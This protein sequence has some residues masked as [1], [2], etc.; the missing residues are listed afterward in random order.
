MEEPLRIS[1]GKMIIGSK[2]VEEYVVLINGKKNDEKIRVLFINFATS[3]TLEFFEFNNSKILADEI[4]DLFQQKKIKTVILN[5]FEV[6]TVDFKNNVEFCK[7]LQ[8]KFYFFRIPFY[9]ISPFNFYLNKKIIAANVEINVGD[10]LLMFDIDDDKFDAAELNFTNDGYEYINLPKIEYFGNEKLMAQCLQD[11][12]VAECKP[13]KIIL[14]SEFSDL[15]LMNKIKEFFFKSM[16]EKTIFLNGFLNEFNPKCS[17]EISKWMFDKNNNKFLSINK[18]WR[19]FCIENI[20]GQKKFKIIISNDENMDL[21]FQKSVIV[22]YSPFDFFFGYYDSDL[23]DFVV[24]DEFKLDSNFHEH[25]ICLK[26]DSNHFSSYKLYGSL[27]PEIQ[28][29]PDK[30]N[31]NISSK[32]PVITFFNNSSFISVDKGHGYE[33]LKIWNDVYGEQM[34]ISFDEKQPKFGESAIEV[35]K[36]KPTT[37]IFDILSILAKDGKCFESSWGFEIKKNE[38]GEILFEFDNFDGIRRKSSA[39]FFLSLLIRR[40]INAI[41]IEVG[42]RP[43]AICLHILVPSNNKEIIMKSFEEACKP[44]EIDCSFF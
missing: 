23:K 13:L 35:F 5:V 39:Y 4:L 28:G 18:T 1:L 10:S 20:F 19:Q 16:P 32:I 29:L 34:F 3:E 15:P 27:I 17:V 43:P 8:A 11:V 12:I 36:N 14:A 25:K 2:K 7:V 30:F 22:P 33:F 24:L 41:G 31:A 26:I 37:V 6:K 40:Q 38:S 44:L 42:Q 21:P 9:F